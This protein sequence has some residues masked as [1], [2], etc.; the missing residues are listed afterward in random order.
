MITDHELEADLMDLA[1]AIPVAV[2]RWEPPAEH[3]HASRG[4]VLAASAAV[5]LVVASAVAIVSAARNDQ[6]GGYALDSTDGR[7][8]PLLDSCAGI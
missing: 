8:A 7:A 5:V 6:R 2:P 4:K 3:R 1:S